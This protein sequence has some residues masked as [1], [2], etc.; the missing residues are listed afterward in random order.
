[1]NEEDS[2]FYPAGL[3]ARW[4]PDRPMASETT[5]AS[6]ERRMELNIA[7]RDL[8][9][10]RLLRVTAIDVDAYALNVRYEVTPPINVRPED[11][12]DGGLLKYAWY[13]AGR[14]DLGNEYDSGGGAYGLAADGQRTKGVHSLIPTPAAGASRLDIAFYTD[15]AGGSQHPFES[16]R[17]VLRVDLPLETP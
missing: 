6:P 12:S 7:I 15:T 4:P 1:M 16:A 17:Y 2:D 14:D 8:L 9:P 11:V 13:L 10:D 3:Y 5:A